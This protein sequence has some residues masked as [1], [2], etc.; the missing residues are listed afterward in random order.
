V[1]GNL[2]FVLLVQENR[3]R[4]PEEPTTAAA[5][6]TAKAVATFDITTEFDRDKASQS[7]LA[8]HVVDEIKCAQ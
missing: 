1:C 2:N 6:L 8:S 5:Q 3:R 4:G 7:D